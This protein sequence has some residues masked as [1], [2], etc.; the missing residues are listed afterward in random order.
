M[1][2]YAKSNVCGANVRPEEA[3]RRLKTVKLPTKREANGKNQAMHLRAV[4]LKQKP[5]EVTICE[6]T[7]A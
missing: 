3:W 7:H 2:G 5:T 4:V 1:A 6:V